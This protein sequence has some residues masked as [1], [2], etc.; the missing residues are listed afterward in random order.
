MSSLELILNYVAPVALALIMCGMGLTIRFKAFQDLAKAPKAVVIGLSA[1]IFILPAIGTAI[2]IWQDLPPDLALGLILLSTCPGGTTSNILAFI[3]RAD[4]ALSILLTTLS[5]FLIIVTMPLALYLSTEYFL[6]L[7]VGSVEIPKMTLITQLFALT[8]APVSIGM[9]I[10][11]IFPHAADRI[12]KPTRIFS[13][14]TLLILVSALIFKESEYMITNIRTAGGL[15]IELLF[16][17]MMVS[18][19]LAKVFRLSI[20]Q[21][22]SI[23]VEVGMQNGLLAII[24]ATSV[25]GNTKLALFPS[26][27][28]MISLLVVGVISIMYTYLSG[29]RESEQCSES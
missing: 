13:S 8:L 27:Y 29:R 14:I 21:R 26:A 25:I 6:G 17:T 12:E 24:I 9:I 11:N 4:V 20:P 2:A 1:Q 28:G 16:I 23:I 22:L 19:G 3:L 18:Y 7:E 15:V 10:G 5:S